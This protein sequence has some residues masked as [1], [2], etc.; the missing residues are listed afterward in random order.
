MIAAIIGIRSVKK[1]YHY[2]DMVSKEIHS[3]I[4]EVKKCSPI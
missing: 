4:R 2:N 3:T 1:V